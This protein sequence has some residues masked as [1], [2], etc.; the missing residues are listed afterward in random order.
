MEIIEFK[1]YPNTETPMSSHN[2]NRMQNN[3]KTELTNIEQ[4]GIIVSP[5][6]PTTNRR[7]VWMQKGK[8][9]FN[10]NNANIISGYMSGGVHKIFK[11]NTNAD[12][13]IYIKCNPNTTYTVSKCV[14]S[15]FAVCAINE[16][17]TTSEKDITN[18]IVDNNEQSI[19]I[20][21][22]TNECYLYV[23]YYTSGDNEQEIL[24][25][26]QIEQGSTATEYEEYIEPKMYILNDNNVYEEFMKKE[27][28]EGTSLWIG[29]SFAETI[30]LSDNPLNYRY[31]LVKT[32]SGYNAI[33]PALTGGSAVTGRSLVENS[34]YSRY[35]LFFYINNINNANKTILFA[36]TYLFKNGAYSSMAQ[37]TEIIGYKD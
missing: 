2:L 29:S 8:N 33:V 23:Y 19:T 25:S 37:I 26:I 12:K 17:L 24:N 35:E 11:N 6:E 27:E 31:F 1:D 5:T 36:P 28:S 20:T 7:K 3:I 13:M 34:T 22:G 32:S 4:E 14:S 21:T 10:K 15:R 30:T 16:I 18:V 9:L